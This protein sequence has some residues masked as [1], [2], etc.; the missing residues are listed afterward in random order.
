MRAQL[1]NT[2]L[3]NLEAAAKK[4]NAAQISLTSCSQFT[5][6]VIILPCVLITGPIHLRMT[7]KWTLISAVDTRGGSIQFLTKQI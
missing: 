7:Y 1:A 6:L 4:K 5:Y 2:E 3:Q